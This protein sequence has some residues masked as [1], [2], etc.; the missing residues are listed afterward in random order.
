MP[1]KESKIDQ[2]KRGGSVLCTENTEV[3]C[4]ERKIRPKEDTAQLSSKFS[5]TNMPGKFVGRCEQPDE[6]SAPSIITQKAVRQSDLTS[7]HIHTEKRSGR[8]KPEIFLFFSVPCGLSW[9]FLT[10][11]QGPSPAFGA[12]CCPDHRPCL[13]SVFANTTWH[14]KA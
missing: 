9:S 4:R 3:R 2:I 5:L 13:L 7:L 14:R 8:A 12:Y 6:K 11:K 10:S 1:D